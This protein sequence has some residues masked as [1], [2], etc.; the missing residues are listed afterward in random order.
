MIFFT[1]NPTKKKKNFLWGVG[2]VDGGGAG[3]R[4]SDFFLLRIQIQNLK[5]GDGGV[6]VGVGAGVSDFLSMNPNSK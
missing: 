1:K 5:K 2:L 3:A 6:G 4:V